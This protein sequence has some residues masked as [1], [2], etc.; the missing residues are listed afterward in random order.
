M[1][2]K[3]III[4][5]KANGKKRAK[6]SKHFFF[7]EQT[8]AYIYHGHGECSLDPSKCVCVCTLYTSAAYQKVTDYSRPHG[9]VCVSVYYGKRNDSEDEPNNID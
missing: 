7:S 3:W 2:T 1:Q 9:H 4:M 8:N 5:L 6:G